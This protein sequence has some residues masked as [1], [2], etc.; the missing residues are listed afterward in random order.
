MMSVLR[1]PVLLLSVVATV[2]VPGVFTVFAFV[3]HEH[4]IEASM[5]RTS[6]AAAAPL[7]PSPVIP[8]PAADATPA[9]AA[10]GTPVSPEPESQARARGVQMLL[11]AAEAA[12]A[13]SY[14]GVEVIND[15]TMT[16]ESAVTATVWHR[17]G[18]QAVV[19]VSDG[20]SYNSGVSGDRDPQGVFGVTTALVELLA[21]HYTVEYQGASSALGRAALIVTVR[22]PDESLAARF[23]LDAQTMLP[24]RKD[25]YGTTARLVSDDRFVSVRFGATAMP[26]ASAAPDQVSWSQAPSPATLLKK[27]GCPV[28]GTLPGDMNLYDASQEATPNGQV[29]DFEFSDGLSV[30]SLFVQRGTLPAKMPG[31]R[32]ATISGHE[33]YVS[34]QEIVLGG[35][36][37][38]YTFIAD[39]PPQTVDA[40]VSDVASNGQTG[41]LGRLGRGLS[42]IVSVLDPFN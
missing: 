37:F 36:G 34:N 6:T 38:V 25:V 4:A 11:R 22:R 33:V 9:G 12:H 15:T 1:R 17:Q 28:P 20:Q 19:Q 39:A 41:V 42:R 24:L 13:A 27:L 21:K 40:A 29:T 16:G 31:W 32:T 26:R 7:N 10:D 5:A 35:Q 2:T 14:Q 3:G 30:M 18:D 8:S 23:W